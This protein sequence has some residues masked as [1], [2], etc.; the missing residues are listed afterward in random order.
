M[1]LRI[2]QTS[3]SVKI[4]TR[5]SLSSVQV[6]HFLKNLLHFGVIVDGR[7]MLDVPSLR[8]VAGVQ[9]CLA[10]KM[11]D[12]FMVQH[13]RCACRCTLTGTKVTTKALHRLANNNPTAS[14]ILCG[15]YTL[16]SKCILY[17]KYM[18]CS[19]ILC[20]NYTRHKRSR[21]PHY[22]LK[23]AAGHVR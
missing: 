22:N 19:K 16:S 11:L 7:N 9:L 12:T 15:T 18:L 17:S 23:T 10:S 5:E 3:R 1:Y 20:S 6:N 8:R 4:H 21:V 13:P 2:T 14:Y